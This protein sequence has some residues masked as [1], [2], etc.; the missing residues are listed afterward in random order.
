MVDWC[1]YL[2]R[3]E[4]PAEAGSLPDPPHSP[5]HEYIDEVMDDVAMETCPIWP[6]IEV[7]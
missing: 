3:L 6:T 7:H 4:S 1:S 2:D 5:Y